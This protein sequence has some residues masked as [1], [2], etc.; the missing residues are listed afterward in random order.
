VGDTGDHVITVTASDA[1]GH[2]AHASQTI[3]INAAPTLTIQS[4]LPGTSVGVGGA[5]TFTAL[6]T[7]MTSPTYAV[8]D[9]FIRST[10]SNTNINGSG[11][12]SW[13][14][15]SNETGTH[16]L[17]IIVTDAATGRTMSITQTINVMIPNVSIQGATG[18]LTA[19][20]ST[21][22]FNVS[23]N[24]YVNPTY[25][26][27]DLFSGGTVSSGN[28]S[29]SGSFSW[30]PTARDI[31]NHTFSVAVSDASGHTGTVVQTFVVQGPSIM[32]QSVFPSTSVAV[33]TT[34]SFVVSSLLFINPI[35][36]LSDSFTG[37]TT[38]SN[39][40]ISTNGNFS[41]VPKV[42]DSGVHTLRI[43]ANDTSGHSTSTAITLL[44]NASAVFPTPVTTLTTSP[45][46]ENIVLISLLSKG[47][48]GTEVTKLQT[49]L[50]QKG[51]FSGTPNGAFG[52]L[53]EAAV[54]RFQ[55]TQ[56]LSPLG[57]IDPQTRDALNKLSSGT[58]ATPSMPS[59]T[60]FRFMHP[61]ALG[62]HGNDVSELQKRLIVLGVYTG[63]IS[64]Y[65][66]PLTQTAV[67]L[68]QSKHNLEQLGSVGPGTRA[69]L[70]AQ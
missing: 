7:G 36:T 22:S 10:I 52:P 5:V 23:T 61:L 63:S 67:K 37:Q 13:T 43:S 20:G 4:L 46:Q 70:N 17:F 69:A 32:I 27:T 50:S 59:A 56:G 54:K 53:T 12:F 66:G 21:V 29:S 68:F 60:S 26:V 48:S 40:N 30:I 24:G 39:A 62:T 15:T 31:G 2:S 55:S 51:Y 18:S 65:F 58:L 16:N 44:V 35:Y 14:P 47:S 38:L 9:N 8:S 19:P 64:G 34:L 57:A 25:T 42:S 33:G 41:W 28:M 11:Q 6:Q 3:S 45:S 1:S 49:L